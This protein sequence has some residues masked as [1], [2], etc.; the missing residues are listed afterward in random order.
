MIRKILEASPIPNQITATVIMATDGMKRRNSVYGS[1]TW[2]TGRNE[3]MARPMGM[4]SREPAKNPIRMRWTLAHRCSSSTPLR[5]R[6]TALRK[7]IAGGGKRT[8]LTR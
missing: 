8:E 5:T 7:T 3:P 6:M 4:P 2:R 1:R